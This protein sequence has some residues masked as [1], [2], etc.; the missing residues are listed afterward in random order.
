MYEIVMTKEAAKQLKKIPK[1]DQEKL[2][3]NIQ[4]LSDNPRP[5]GIK[6]LQG[7]LSQ[8]YHE[9]WKL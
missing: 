2:S 5:N 4:K 6:S 8:Y 7:K 1:K 3:R 9:M